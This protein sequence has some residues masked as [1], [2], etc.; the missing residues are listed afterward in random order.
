MKGIKTVVFLVLFI[1]NGAFAAFGEKVATF[2]F[3][4]AQFAMHPTKNHLYVTSSSLN[5]IMIINT[6]TLTLIDTVL[7]GS[8]P[9]GLAFSESGDKLYVAT[10]GATYIEVID[11]NTLEIVE[12]LS[13]PQSPYDLEMGSNG[14]LYAT[15][16]LQS[17]DIMRV[18]SNSGNYLGNFSGGVFIYSDGLLQV[19]ADKQYL[20]FCNRGLSP[21]TLAKFNISGSSPIFE[22]KNGHGA[23]GSNGQDIALSYSG[24]WVT[25]AV[26]GG[27]IGYDIALIHSTNFSILGTFNLGAYPREAQFSPDDKIFYAV[28]TAGHIDI[29]DTETFLQLPSIPISGEATE[30]FVEPRGRYLFAAVGSELRVYDTGRSVYISKLESIEINGPNKVDENTSTNYEAVAYYDDGSTKDVTALAQWSV[31]DN[32]GIAQINTNGIMT[33][34]KLLTLEEEIAVSASYSE[35]GV[36]VSAQKPVIVYANC[37]IA[38]LVGRNI[39]SAV[40]IKEEVI[41][42]LNE[43]MKRERRAKELLSEFEN[44]PSF[45]NWKFPD[46]I[47]ARNNLN[48]AILKENLCSSYISVLYYLSGR[49]RPGAGKRAAGTDH[50]ESRP[51]ALNELIT[52]R[53]RICLR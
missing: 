11:T 18:D 38:E 52:Q 1:S 26:G 32:N 13:V 15:P 8:L 3:P 47:K 37:T 21:G 25:Y 2:N 36:D 48:W 28:H 43:A 42:N 12:S 9:Q 49:N 17:I 53:R 4:A 14:I 40:A 35:E 5:S 44:D 29:W 6:S 31:V 46:F 7:V 24:D 19:S 51:G 33:T 27:N 50:T 16:A 30:L 45:E 20:Y 39:D 10:S 34:G 23:L 41:N 22:W